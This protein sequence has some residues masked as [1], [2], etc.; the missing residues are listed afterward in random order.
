MTDK[1]LSPHAQSTLVQI[2]KR[3]RMFIHDH[4]HPTNKTVRALRELHEHG[5]IGAVQV[6]DSVLGPGTLFLAPVICDTTE[7]TVRTKTDKRFVVEGIDDELNLTA[8]KI[9]NTA[10]M[11]ARSLLSL[12]ENLEAGRFSAGYINS[13]GLL[14]AASSEIDTGC[15]RIATLAKI[16][17]EI[18]MHMEPYG[19]DGDE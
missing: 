9:G 2:A 17:A 7:G 5:D 12:A 19:K 15:A 14:Q 4:Y 18:V 11:V 6:V 8:T 3:G 16:R 10:R 1:A 13:L